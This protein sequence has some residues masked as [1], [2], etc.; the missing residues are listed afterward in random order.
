MELIRKNLTY[1]IGGRRLLTQ[2]TFDDDINVSDNNAD[3]RIIIMQTGHVR[4]DEIRVLG[5]KIRLAGH[6]EFSVLYSSEENGML[7]CIRGDF[8]FEEMVNYDGGQDGEQV[9]VLWDMEDLRAQMINSRKMNVK[10]VVTFSLYPFRMEEIQAA[11]GV[12]NAIPNAVPDTMPGAVSGTAPGTAP[13]AVSPE[14]LSRTEQFAGLKVCGRDTLR[15]KETFPLPGGKPDVDR[16]VFQDVQLR[17]VKNRPENGHLA[18]SGD[19]F[20][21]VLYRSADEHVPMQWFEK[22]ISVSGEVESHRASDLMLS[23]S[24]IRLAHTE[25]SAAEDEDGEMRRIE[26]EAVLQC[27]LM[28][29]EEQRLELLEDVYVPEMEFDITRPEIPMTT[30][31]SCNDSRMKTS[32]TM[33]LHAGKPLMQI[34]YTAASVKIEDY[35]PGD[36]GMVLEGVISIDLL[37]QQADPENPFEAGHEDYPFSYTVQMPAGD[38]ENSAQ[39]QTAGSVEQINAVLSGPDE[40]EIRLTAGFST[41]FCREEKMRVITDINMK[42]AAPEK[43]ENMPGITGYL[44]KPQ[45]TL[46]SVARKFYVPLSSIREV[47]SLTSDE[48][49]PGQRLLIVK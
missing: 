46:W 47:N 18:V 23:A 49:K 35:H 25:V 5:G 9:T 11:A 41:V 37:Y 32:M 26:V 45:D 31:V 21:F 17:N 10:A 22:Q 15:M 38:P 36:G 29:F 12:E 30:L 16:I 4:L 48:L 8:A 14:T 39:L 7:S 20:L 13:N 24:G 42:P 1:G 44:V 40:A 2:L 28:L 6:L 27:D 43:I 3:I 19:L 33:K 34:V